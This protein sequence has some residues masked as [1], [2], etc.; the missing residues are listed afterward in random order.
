[1]NIT[2]E[3]NFSPRFEYIDYKPK[4]DPNYL[5]FISG[6][7]MPFKEYIIKF[8]IKNEFE[9]EIYNKFHNKDGK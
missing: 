7:N 6:N 8:T 4:L 1:M 5:I 9:Q 2:Q 3:I